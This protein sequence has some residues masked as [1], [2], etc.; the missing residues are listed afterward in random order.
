MANR[1]TQSAIAACQIRRDVVFKALVHEQTGILRDIG[2]IA[3]N[4]A[5]W[6]V[7]IVAAAVRIDRDGGHL[8]AGKAYDCD[9]VIRAGLR[10]AVADGLHELSRSRF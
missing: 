9:A 8:V 4:V 10:R 1:A 5:V 3:Q 6:D 7:Y 2:A